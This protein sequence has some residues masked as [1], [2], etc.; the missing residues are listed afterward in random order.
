MRLAWLSNT[1]PD[2]LYEISQLAQVT[3]LRYDT[4][5]KRIVQRANRAVRYAHNNP[6][7]IM[8]PKLEAKSLRIV[9]YSDAGYS[10]NNDLS[11]QLG[12]IV[13]LMDE[14]GAA[15]PIIFK[16]YKSRRISRSVLSAEANAFADL[17]D[18]AYALRSQLEH[19]L[20]RA[21]PVHLLTDSKSLFDV[22]SK[23]TRTKEKRIML[24]IHAA[25]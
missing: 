8:F 24:D 4:E 7:K 1:R 9:G 23:G 20:S 13:L 17:Y 25:R 14:S 22:I 2:L 15:A 11:S 18:D 16:S 5:K 10:S 19:A 6:S 3:Q 21:V 12:R